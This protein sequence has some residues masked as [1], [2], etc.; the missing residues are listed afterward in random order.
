[1][2]VK[3]AMKVLSRA[4]KKDPG[5]AWG[6]HCN[7]AMVAQDAG[8]AHHEANIRTCAFMKSVFGIDTLKRKR[9]P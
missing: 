5:Y 6:W 1:M 8:A 7:I 4:M 2:L 3:L 9:L